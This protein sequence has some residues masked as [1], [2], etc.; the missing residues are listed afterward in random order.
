L[1]AVGGNVAWADSF[2]YLA[3]TGFL[4]GFG[5]G[6]CPDI[7]RAANW[8]TIEMTGVGTLSTHPKSVTGGGTFTHK[9]A[10]GAVIASGIWTAI[11]LLS[12]NDYG[13]NPALPPDVH[14][15]RAT[16]RVHLIPATGGPGVHGILQIDCG[17]NLAPG[18][19]PEEKKGLNVGRGHPEGI[20]LSVDGGLNFN[21]EISGLTVFLEIP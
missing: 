17:V 9:E 18:F 21:E 8:D 10:A 14:G 1:F 7:S 3:G 19:K 5:P 11:E 16:I 4:C 2:T 15:G 6:S 13:T 12:F 20:R